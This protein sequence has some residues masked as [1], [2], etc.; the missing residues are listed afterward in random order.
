MK[1]I[2]GIATS[3]ALLAGILYSGFTNAQQYVTTVGIQYK[4]IIP[5]VFF[6]KDGF[7]SKTDTISLSI[8]PKNGSSFGMVVRRGISENFSVESGINMVTRNYTI[9]ASAKDTNLNFQDQVKWIAYEI[10]VQLL[11]FIRLGEKTY[12][13]AAGGIAL[14]FFPTDIKSENADF[15]LRTRRHHWWSQNLIGNLGFEYRTES[16]GYFYIGASYLQPFTYM[17]TTQV[18]YL[19]TNPMNTVKDQLRGNYLTLD[20]RYF[21]HEDPNKATR[22]KVREYKEKVNMK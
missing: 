1:N 22:K 9:N 2:Y 18:N 20:L 12:L 11:V 6:R 10:P 19:N 8:Q 3:L 14:N 21:F 16:S 7:E 15:Y 4:P 13:N 17:A 5:S